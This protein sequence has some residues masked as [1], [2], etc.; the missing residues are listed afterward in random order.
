LKFLCLIREKKE[1][2]AKV[3]QRLSV[4]Y[5]VLG[6]D[7]GRSASQSLRLGSNLGVGRPDEAADDL[8]A[9]G[10]VGVRAAQ[11]VQLLQGIDVHSDRYNV[12]H[13]IAPRS[14]WLRIAAIA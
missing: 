13:A 14:G 3:W 8:D 6:G 5:R 10:D 4:C 12:F 7:Y 9:R 2:A 1:G 11:V